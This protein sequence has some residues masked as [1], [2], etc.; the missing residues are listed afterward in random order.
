MNTI[1]N[2][3]NEGINLNAN[4]AFERAI[5]STIMFEPKQFDDIST[6]LKPHHFFD[7]THREIFEGMV[8]LKEKDLPIDDS[9][10]AQELKRFN[11]KV[12]IDVLTTNPVSNF[13]PYITSIIDFYQKRETYKI[14]LRSIT[15]LSEST[16]DEVINTLLDA[17]DKIDKPEKTRAKSFDE[18]KENFLILP[19]EPIYPTGVS[20]LD[21]ALKDDSE[22][23]KGGLETGQL[24][25]VSGDPEAGKTMLGMQI[26]KNVTK[27]EE[28]LLF[29][30]EFTTKQLVK[31]QLKETVEGK[32]Y[33]NHNLMVI[34]DGYDITDII[35]ELKFWRKKG[36]RFV[37]IDSQMRIENSFT[38]G[39]T[40]EERESEKFS[41]LAK[42]AHRNDM[43]IILIIQTS[44]ADASASVIS[45]MGSK[46]GAHEASIILHLKRVKEDDKT[47][48]KELRE[49]ILSKNKQNGVHFKGKIVFNPYTLKFTRPYTKGEASMTVEYKNKNGSTTKH[50]TIDLFQSG[51]GMSDSLNIPF[52]GD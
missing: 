36:V 41:K 15:L 14:L 12:F 51:G 37:M 17:Y 22:K 26:L 49:L 2:T 18:L 30:F 23:H 16:P 24:V 5:L 29:A 13:L 45:P 28:A 33:S 39:V 46:K 8:S 7:I 20:F 25:L 44:K 43:I 3:V 4:I 35:G 11:E 34:D 6:N 31:T 48:Q 38:K 32:N 19:P 50:E 1:E 47:G 40:L 42:F 10:L 21:D 27:E 9:Y 52:I